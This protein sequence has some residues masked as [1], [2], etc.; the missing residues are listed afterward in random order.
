MPFLGISLYAL[1]RC[2]SPQGLV[3]NVLGLGAFLAQPRLLVRLVLLVIPVEKGHL[4]IA[5]EGQDMGGDA[6][7]EPVVA[8]SP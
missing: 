8:K 6:A 7:Q 4:Q 5:F 2:L 1:P 3:P